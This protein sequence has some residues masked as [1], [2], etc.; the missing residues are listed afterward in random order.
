MNTP[1]ITLTQEELLSL[2]TEVRQKL[3]E[4]IT[5]KRVSPAIQTTVAAN[6][7]TLPFAAMEEVVSPGAQSLLVNSTPPPGATVVSDPIEIYY[8]SCASDEN[9]QTIIV[10]QELHALRS[11][12]LVINE[13]DG[14]ES[15][16]DPGCQIIA[17]S[18]TV[19]FNL[20]L[21]YDPTIILQM[22]SANGEVNPSLSIAR[23]VR[24]RIG[25]IDIYLQIHVI[26]QP[27]YDI[28]LGRPFDVLMQSTVQN[29]ADENQTIT[30][31]DPNSNRV[32][33]IPTFA[34]GPP[35]HRKRN[36]QPRQPKS[37]EAHAR[38]SNSGF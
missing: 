27:A 37:K 34:R 3:R 7:S 24:C 8:N 29:F 17:M 19:C 1:Y 33:T 13:G 4:A 23:N 6:M 30:I 11:I 10:A 31:R 20:G 12:D 16:L 21:I 36:A 18:E 25:N 26:R 5:A 32:V 28:L 14:V 22:E 2:S 9:R 15:I 35:R 38:E